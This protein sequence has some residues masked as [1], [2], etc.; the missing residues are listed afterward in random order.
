MSKTKGYVSLIIIISLIVGA[1]GGV[2]GSFFLKPYIESTA[3]G[4]QFLHNDVTQT[5]TGQKKVYE[6]TE[7]S[8]TFDV[9]K[10]V[11]PSVVSVVVTKE[12][13]NVYNMTGPDVWEFWNNGE[14]LPRGGGDTQEVGGGTGFIISEDGMILTNRHVVEDIDAA[15]SIV[16]NDG[17]SHEAKV[18]DRDVVSDIAVLQIDVQG[19]PV[20]E[21][22]DSDDIEIGQ[23]VV[24]IGNT[25]SEYSNTVTRGVISGIDRRVVAGDGFG[26]SELIEGALQT[27]AAINPGNSGGPLLNLDGQVIGINTAVNRAGQSIGFAIPINQA[28]PVVDSV[29]EFGEIVRPW[30]GVRYVN[31]TEEA[32]EVNELSHNYGALIVD[33]ET[34]TPGVVVDSPAANAGLLEGDIILSINGVDLR[35]DTSL[36]KEISKYKPGEIIEIIYAREG[37]EIPVSVTLDKRGDL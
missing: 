28:K 9:V 26:N 31:L 3:W 20:V 27:D 30:L 17:T 4:I 24:A 18:L 11:A 12:L 7:N 1:I 29:R 33:G 6:V 37:N 16:L 23:T 35:D 21:F 15:Y 36:V 13:A 22:G 25:L 34:S 19:L 2:F 8:A 5:I 10:K 32:A 14:P